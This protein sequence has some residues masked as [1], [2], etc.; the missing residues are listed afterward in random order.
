MGNQYDRIQIADFLITAAI[1]SIQL[2]VYLNT[3]IIIKKSLNRLY[4]TAAIAEE[5]ASLR[6]QNPINKKLI[7]LIISHPTTN[8]INFLTK[9][10]IILNLKI[11]IKPLKITPPISLSMY[12]DTNATIRVYT[13]STIGITLKMSHPSSQGI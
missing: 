6:A 4:I 1:S 13:V 12:Q 3:N 2:P 10:I 11:P 5:L 9:N 7:N 8:L